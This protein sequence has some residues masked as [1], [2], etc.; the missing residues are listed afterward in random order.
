MNIITI[1]GAAGNPTGEAWLT[2]DSGDLVPAEN[3][4]WDEALLEAASS[5]AVPILRFYG[6][7]SVAATFGYF[8]RFSNVAAWT[9]LRPLIRR[10]TGGGLVSHLADWTYSLVFPKS[11]WWYSLPAIE[12]YL[13]M[14][15]WI[16]RSLAQIGIEAVLSG[17]RIEAQ[18][19]CCFSGAEK[20]DLLNGSRKIAG[21]AQR[22]TQAGLLIQGS[23]QP[24]PPLPERAKWQI[25]ML[26]TAPIQADWKRFD[27]SLSMNE[28][29]SNLTTEKYADCVYNEK[30]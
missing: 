12:S 9:P 29:V 15:K 10:P 3:M 19:G 13:T 6:W 27:P 1:P 24:C 16:S 7:N 2:L 20:N 14:H 8:Q 5:L 4:A 28:R 25:A 11:H 21:A 30:R 23:V 22:R 17:D 26:K 18:R